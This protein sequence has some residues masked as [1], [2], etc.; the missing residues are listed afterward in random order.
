M[1]YQNGDYM[2]YQNEHNGDYGSAL[3]KENENLSLDPWVPSLG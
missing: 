2:D 1:D 3:E